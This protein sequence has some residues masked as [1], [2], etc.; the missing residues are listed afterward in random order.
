M[1]PEGRIEAI[2]LTTIEDQLEEWINEGNSIPKWG[3]WDC[4]IPHYHPFEP[5]D[6]IC[7]P[8]N[9]F[10][11]CDVGWGSSIGR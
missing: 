1:I 8:I 9:C 11:I 7:D 5:C 4:D 2:I 10:G 6:P 3:E